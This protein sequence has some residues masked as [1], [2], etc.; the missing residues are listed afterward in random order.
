MYAA[1]FR[2]VARHK[3][4]LVMSELPSGFTDSRNRSADCRY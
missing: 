3:I 4:S 1:R 2:P